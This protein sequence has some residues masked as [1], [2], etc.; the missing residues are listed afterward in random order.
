MVSAFERSFVVRRRF[1]FVSATAADAVNVAAFF[2][3]NSCT[4]AL[5][6]QREERAGFLYGQ[7]CCSSSD[8]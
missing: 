3:T 7:R 6:Y 8:E 5:G 4:P 2:L 1:A